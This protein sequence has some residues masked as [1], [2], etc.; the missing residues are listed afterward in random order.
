MVNTKVLV[1]M[2]VCDCME[3]VCENV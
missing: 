1:K 3:S 2:I